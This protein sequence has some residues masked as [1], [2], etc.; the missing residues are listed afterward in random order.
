MNL[1][2][3]PHKIT[4]QEGLFS[5]GHNTA[6]VLDEV[7]DD[8]DLQTARL[9]Q[10]EIKKVIAITLPIKKMIRNSVNLYERCICFEYNKMDERAEAY[11]LSVAPNKITIVACSNRGY[12]LDVKPGESFTWY[13]RM[14][15]H[16]IN[17]SDP[18]SFTLITGILDQYMP[19]F[20]SDKINICCDETFGLGRYRTKIS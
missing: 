5:I 19:L 12:M 15:Y 9:L 6:I 2:P 3:F 7:M 8:N 10:Q 17:V 1:I 4:T 16:T 18:G 14:R 13:N 20:R 11:R